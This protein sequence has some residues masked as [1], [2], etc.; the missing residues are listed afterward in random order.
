[1][2]L[3]WNSVQQNDDPTSYPFEKAVNPEVVGESDRVL[4]LKG[5][6]LSCGAGIIST[7]FRLLKACLNFGKD[8]LNRW[9]IGQ[10]F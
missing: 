5:R 3:F 10:R 6:Q 8:S 9:I 1:M 2:P 4:N 7:L